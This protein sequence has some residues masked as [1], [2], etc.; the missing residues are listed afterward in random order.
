MVLTLQTCKTVRS[1]QNCC[2]LT[3]RLSNL[4][5]D[6]SNK[7]IVNL[8]DEKLR[9]EGV[10]LPIPHLKHHVQQYSNLMWAGVG[11]GLGD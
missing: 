8:D 7:T 10:F 11:L 4:I 9:I 6:K 5:N 2:N 3:F 1:L